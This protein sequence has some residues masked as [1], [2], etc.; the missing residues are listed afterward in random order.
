MSETPPTSLAGKPIR[1]KGV[2]SFTTRRVYPRGVWEL[3]G[4]HISNLF[5]E[6]EHM[7]IHDNAKK[8]ILIWVV[9]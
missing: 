9:L 8:F 1:Q 3:V 5:L 2:I 6:N 4:H 7:T